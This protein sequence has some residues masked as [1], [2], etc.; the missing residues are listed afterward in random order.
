MGPYNL[1]LM[2]F[3]CIK[4]KLIFVFLLLVNGNAA[5]DIRLANGNETAGRVEVLYNGQWGTVCDDHWTIE[6]AQVVCRQLHLGEAIGVT[7]KARIFGPGTGDIVLDN[8]VC[9]GDET[10]LAQCRHRGF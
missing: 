7:K 9:S 8:V 6:D 2:M 5:I 4:M 3:S 10:N 1:Y